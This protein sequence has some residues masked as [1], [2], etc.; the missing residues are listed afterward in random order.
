MLWKEAVALNSRH[1]KGLRDPI[2]AASGL[3]SQRLCVL[4][5]R[6]GAVTKPGLWIL[7]GSFLGMKTTVDSQNKL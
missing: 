2:K 6:V 4:L 5:G 7:S 1:P 3:S